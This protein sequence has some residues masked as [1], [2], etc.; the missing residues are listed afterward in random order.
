MD[1]QMKLVNDNFVLRYRSPETA[2]LPDWAVWRDAAYGT[3]FE[4]AVFVYSKRRKKRKPGPMQTMNN[5][6]WQRARTQA[7]LGDLHVHDLRHTVVTDLLEAGEPEHV[8]EAVTG[9][10]VPQDAGALLAPAAQGQGPDARAARGAAQEGNRV[11]GY[12]KTPVARIDRQRLQRSRSTISW[13][14]RRT[15]GP[16]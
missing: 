12:Q 3:T 8:I 15:R 11:R 9:H 5:T 4:P 13:I 16:H 1:L 7:G 14:D 2:S 10:L 6:A